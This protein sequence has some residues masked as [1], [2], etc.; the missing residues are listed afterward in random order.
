MGGLP[1]TVAGA[2]FVAIL[3]RTAGPPPINDL[4]TDLEDPPVFTHAAAL[5]TNVDRDMRYPAEFA[6]VQRKCCPD[7]RATLLPKAVEPTVELALDQ[8]QASGWEVTFVDRTA[9]RLEAVATTPL[10]G[11]RDDLVIRIRPAPGG[12][13][14]LDVRSKSRDGTGDA[15]ANAHR[16]RRF[17][18]SMES[19]A[20]PP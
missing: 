17:V 14:T 9:G 8:A 7:L 16:I 3:I 13:S 2:I 15:G 19:A 18:A 4:T 5:D 1:A 6:A 20:A 11:F 12:K 10:F